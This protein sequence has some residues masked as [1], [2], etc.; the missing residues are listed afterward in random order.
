MYPLLEG[1]RVLDCTRLLPG[2]LCTLVLA[3]LGAEVIKVEPPGIGDPS[4]WI[5][6]MQRMEGVGFLALNRNKK[7]LALDPGHEEGRSLL[8]RLADSVDVM[9]E[10]YR[11]GVAARLGID[12]ETVRARNPAI[13]YCSLSGFGQE[14]PMAA[15]AGHDLNYLALSGL[16]SLFA[17][18][19][20]QPV[21]PPIQI[22]DIGGGSLPAVIGIL[23]ALLRRSVT[24]RGDYV[25]V[26]ILDG[27]LMWASLLVSASHALNR[28]PEPGEG[29]LAGATPCYNI[30]RT[31]DDR[32][33]TLGAIEPK[34][35]RTFLELIGKPDLLDRQFDE[36]DE[37]QSVKA[38]IQQ[39]IGQKTVAEWNAVF[40]GHDVC[41]EPVLTIAEAIDRDH[42]KYRNILT[43]ID[44]ETEGHL[45]HIAHPVRYQSVG[46][47][48]DL[49]PPSLGQHTD[50]I[51]RGL[52]LSDEDI[53][54][55]KKK[56]IVG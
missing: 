4:R 44:H 3:D 32:Y 31:A 11:P 5:Q 15:R 40:D 34:F 54:R 30:Y 17:P 19:G 37:G 45:R 12:S 2:P 7:S 9:I 14:G 28:D 6:P 48:E 52:A 42:V 13:V 26:S 18:K 51:L 55:L 1:I 21:I 23:A 41:L 20:Q 39:C 49:P 33:V 46:R 24:G 56:G 53:A 8:L 22:A 10:S 47:Q 43:E 29:F 35:W 27:T 25:D 38:D 16:L 36:G 50:E